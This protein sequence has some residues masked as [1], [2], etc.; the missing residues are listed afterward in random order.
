MVAFARIAGA[1][2]VINEVCYDNAALADERGDVSSDWIELY[3]RGPEA[4]NIANYGLGDANPYQES[5]GVRLPNYTLRP[6]ACLVVFANGDIPDYTAWVAARD[7]KLIAPNAKWRYR[8]A[9]D[10]P[11]A[12]WKE[13]AFD[14]ASWPFGL[15]PLG[16]NET[17]A[18][19]DCA[20]VLE[21]GADPTN[22][23]PAAYFR[24]AFT[25]DNPSV[26]TGL[27]VRARIDDGMVVY[28]NGLEVLRKNMPEGPVSHD[29][30]A[31]SSV[32]STEWFSVLLATNA[33]VCGK[34]VLA[35]EVHQDLAASPDL[36][37]DMTLTG[38]VSEQVP[39]VHGQFRLAS[40]GE[41]V[42]LFN[43]QLTRVQ[44]FAPPCF[45]IGENQSFG[46]LPDGNTSIFYVFDRPT[47]GQSNATSP[48]RYSETL[49]SAKPV[50]SI[51]PGIYETGQVVKLRTSKSGCKI[52][53]TLDGT[54]PK[55][56][57]AYVV[58]GG[59][60]ALSAAAEATNGLAWIRTNP[61]EMDSRFPAAAWRPPPEPVGRAVVLR[62]VAVAGD[63]VNCSPETSGT[64][65]IGAGFTNRPLPIVSLIVNPADWFGFTEGIYV[66]GKYYA[67]S[68]EGYGGNRW[69][70]PFANYF[71]S[72]AE[73]KW[74]RP[75][76]F[77]WVE[78]EQNQVSVALKLGVTPNGGGTC[79]LPQKSL[80][81]LARAGKY[82][83][84]QIDCAF[85][86]QEP[87]NAFRR[88][89][90]R[91]SGDDWY[92]PDSGGVAT[93]LKDAMFQQLSKPLNLA[94]MAYRPAVAYLNGEYWGLHNVRESFDKFYFATR[95]GVDPENVDLVRQGEDPA[96]PLHV[97]YTVD[98]GD[99]NAGT[100]Y[101]A[102]LNWVAG[103]SL[104][105]EANYQSLQGH[106][107][108]T[109]I[110][111]YVIAETFFANTDWPRNNC[112]FWRAH[113]NQTQA[114]GATGDTRWRWMLNDL[115]RAG[116]KGSGIDMFAY[117]SAEGM[118]EL[119]QPAF[120]INELWKNSGYRASFAAR[121]ERVLNTAF[122][123]EGTAAAISR[124]ADG[125][126]PEIENHFRRWGRPYTQA[127]WRQA[128]DVT[129]IRF[130]AARHAV[131]WG[132]LSDTFALGGSGVVSVR[133][134][135]ED[136]TGGHF[137]VDG[138]NLE[139]ETPGVTSRAQWSGRFFKNRAITV[140]AVPDRHYVFDGWEGRSE[141]NATLSVTAMD[142]EQVLVARFLPVMPSTCETT[143]AGVAFSME[144]PAA[145]DGV[146]P[147]KVT[148][149]GL[150]SGLRYDTATGTIVGSATKTGTFAV[151]IS[152]AGVPSETVTVTVASLPVWA[153]GAFNGYLGGVSGGLAT[154]SITAQ[155]KI[156]GK[157]VF[158]GKG[159]AFRSASYT[160]E[161]A[162]DGAFRIETSATSGAAALPLTLDVQPSPGEFSFGAVAVAKALGVASG[163]LGGSGGVPLLLYRNVWKDPGM[164]AFLADYTGYFTATLPGG[165]E[166]GSG[167]LLFTADQGGG[168]KAAGQLADGTA[169]SQG[170]TLLV[171]ASNHVFAA[172]YAA[173]ASYRGG[174]LFGLAEFV[175][176]DVGRVI[177]RPLDGE[178]FL[179]TSRN[180]LASGTYGA[181]FA[182]ATGLAGGWYERTENLFAYY[183]G[184]ALICGADTDADAPFLLAGTNRYPAAWWRPDGIALTVVTNRSGMM[185]GLAA[186]HAG[187]PM[188]ADG[189]GVWDYGATNA[190]GLTIALTRPTG[191]FKGSFLVWFDDPDRKHVS[192]RVTLQ[193]ALTPVREDRSDGVEGRGFFLWPDQAQPPLPAKPNAFQWSY[194]F[195]L[196]NT[197]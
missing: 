66:P 100:E 155:G 123:P 162:H 182:R 68:P 179:W 67:D 69:G 16:Y 172:V 159:Y 85:F 63:G 88:L 128:V 27:V 186:P 121:Y 32:P 129:L 17:T 10:A 156:T 84:N 62:A 92:G 193:G 166:T 134:S 113:T 140:R 79:A 19:M 116:E 174:G 24:T 191:V 165:S 144:L 103:H 78:P 104:S 3:N 87:V 28:L 89:L 133:N 175:K 49:T 72:N 37:M 108:I 8:S 77:E 20:T 55:E 163:V 2:L 39:V 117:L 97:A 106:V 76:H 44:L 73:Q 61:V 105:Q 26:I 50:F 94:V 114:A 40:S 45:E 102:L 197:Q 43:A 147:K 86:P 164:S 170:G 98:S 130:A 25:V 131:L 96:N 22:R 185:T 192:K 125:I 13:P 132:Q 99:P 150:P 38:L 35:V 189:D 4:V 190:V 142:E 1:V 195:L 194:D 161:D 90:L 41:N 187:K 6:G 7:L 14:D 177:V 126:A 18:N 57:A 110:T 82:G 167:Y 149:R 173:P 136:G 15:S 52:H 36:I 152:A 139:P 56:A 151:V 141:T 51:Q 74:E 34:N 176:P 75:A 137:V 48:V 70:K 145:F 169:V 158:G 178:P 59:S 9:P 135:R 95:Y 29:T 107:D 160:G 153:Q 124:A 46:A 12:A 21:D 171:D 138:I 112:D 91:N 5:H 146:D 122:R 71:Q 42:H 196:L 83:T 127:Q 33:V 168:V 148:V 30:R 119:G 188:D 58:S 143:T 54:D 184:K 101:D 60:V 181:G 11:S 81:L 31:L 53:Y 93:M 118:R 109:N 183:A 115:D 154:M 180:P 80:Q 47:P 111:D 120:L 64:Y 65:F 157:L 23:Y